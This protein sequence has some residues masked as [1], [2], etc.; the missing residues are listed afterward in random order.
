MP[1]YEYRCAA[2]GHVF[3][4]TRKI[5]EYQEPLNN[6]CP[7]CQKLGELAIQPGACGLLFRGGVRRKPDG[8]FNDRLK[9]MKKKHPGNTIN[10]IE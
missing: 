6:P 3:E 7:Q 2:C 5:A 4:E 9:E 10:V 1:I 8:G